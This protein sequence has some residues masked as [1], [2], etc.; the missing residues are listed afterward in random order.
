[1]FSDDDTGVSGEGERGRGLAMEDAETIETGPSL[2]ISVAK[3]D[4]E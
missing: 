4:G 2:L 1:M 3:D